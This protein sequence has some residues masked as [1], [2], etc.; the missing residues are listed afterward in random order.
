MNSR[1]CLWC[2]KD[3][4]G[5]KTREH[6][7][8]ECIGGRKK[9]PIGYVC[10]SCNNSFSHRI[11]RALLKEHSGMMDAY[12]IDTGIER[13]GN[14]KKDILRYKQEKFSIQGVGAASSTRISREGNKINFLNANFEVKSVDFVRSLHKCIANILCD[15]YGPNYVRRNY[16]ELLNF[17]F[18]GG[19]VHPWSYAIS[20]PNLINRPLISEPQIIMSLTIEKNNKTHEIYSFIHTSG[21]WI[22]G[23]SPFILNPDLI[24]KFSNLIILKLAKNKESKSNKPITDFFGFEWN[25]NDR[26]HIG[27]LNFL[28]IVKEL[29]GKPNDDFLYLLTKCKIC[30]Q[31]TPTG[32]VLPRDLIYSGNVNKS[33]YHPKNTWNHYNIEDLKK[34]GLRIDKW[35]EKKLKEYMNQGIRIPIEND[36]KKMKLQNCET[37]CLNCNYVIKFNADDCFI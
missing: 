24:S 12:Q 6:I 27:E 5:D 26:V 23:S 13:K 32:I 35:S 8:P 3:T 36:V 20:F 14:K 19:D 2:G 29:E 28:W 16:P 22:V 15:S 10:K 21:I 7:F 1:I 18:K 11:D 25:K 9:L 31:T 34:L 33:I 30:G 37:N 4:T 17:V